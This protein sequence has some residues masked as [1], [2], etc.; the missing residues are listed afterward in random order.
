M[1]TT[2]IIPFLNEGDE[3]LKTI[4]NI[5]DTTSDHNSFEIFLI[6]DEYKHPPF[7]IPKYSNLKFIKNP[8]RLG[9]SGCRNLGVLMSGSENI[10]LLDAHMRFYNNYWM[11]ILIDNLNKYPR[12]IITPVNKSVKDDK[13]DFESNS[14]RGCKILLKNSDYTRSLDNSILSTKWDIDLFFNDE[15]D[16][17]CIMG[18]CYALK[19]NYYKFL[20]G[21]N[22]LHIWGASEQFIS[23]K[24]WMFG[25]SC[26]NIPHL[27]VG[28]KYKKS[29][30]IKYELHEWYRTYNKLFIIYTL[31]PENLVEKA[32][33]ELLSLNKEPEVLEHMKDTFLNIIAKRKYYQAFIKNDLYWYADKFKF[34]CL[35]PKM[36]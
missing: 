17:A 35:A 22:D 12:S 3:P 31:F 2:I 27:I 4:N 8:Q 26:K 19:R 15:M 33:K 20:D 11:E 25:G 14:G 13:I 30:E 5:Y 36:K 18:G 32:V 6:N 24:S 10:I 34:D 29:N 9:V 28:H 7:V 23:L 21:F 1:K 16:I